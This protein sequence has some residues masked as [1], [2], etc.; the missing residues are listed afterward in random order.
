[1]VVVVLLALDA[2]NRYFWAMRPPKECA[3]ITGGAEPISW[4]TS[5][6][7]WAWLSSVPAA[8]QQHNSTATQQYIVQQYALFTMCST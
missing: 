3:T 8:V 2:F 1:V 5:A 4:T 6:R 7:S